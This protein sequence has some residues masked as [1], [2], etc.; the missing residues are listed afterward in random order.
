MS[1]LYLQIPNEKGSFEIEIVAAGNKFLIKE[2]PEMQGLYKNLFRWISKNSKLSNQDYTGYV[3][4]RAAHPAEDFGIANN[5]YSKSVSVF[6]QSLFG[7][8]EVHSPEPIPSDPFNAPSLDPNPAPLNNLF[9][10]E[11]PAPQG[12]QN[13]KQTSGEVIL[14]DETNTFQQFKVSMS[15]GV[16]QGLGTEFYPSGT[17]KYIGRYMNDTPND[18]SG[19]YFYENSQ[20]MYTGSVVN[21][22]LSGPGQIYHENGV[23]GFVGQFANNSPTGLIKMF[24]RFSNL[25]YSG[26]YSNNQKSG[27]GTEFY[28]NGKIKFQ[29]EFKGDGPHGLNCTLFGYFGNKEF[30]GEMNQGVKAKGKIYLNSGALYYEGGF[31]AGNPSGLRCVTYYETGAKHYEGG[32]KGG[33]YLLIVFFLGMPCWKI[34]RN[35]TLA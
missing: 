26:N 14:M 1:R 20:R 11:P 9:P 35:C 25:S 29:G 24:D 16:K 2:K 22:N 21:G 12:Q 33:Q 23:L 4:A 6:A 5:P 19:T 15:N 28:Y 34:F 8:D 31:E 3:N 7:S 10:S 17:P 30:V 18:P 27:T 13:T 32:L